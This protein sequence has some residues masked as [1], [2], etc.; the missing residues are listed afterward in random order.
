MSGQ[1]YYLLT[2]LP[3]LGELG[4][5][6]P[7][8]P[9]A[10]LEMLATS[11]GAQ[12]LASAIFLSDDLLLRQAVMS[13]EIPAD[14]ADPAVLSTEQV[15]DEAP[16]PDFLAGLTGPDGE[17]AQEDEAAGTARLG[18]DRVWA[19][20]F[21]HAARLARGSEMLSEWV[22]HEVGLRNALAA[23]RAKALGL[24]AARYIV[25]WQLGGSEDEYAAALSEWSAAPN[26]LAGLQALDAARWNWIAQ[27]S[28]HFTFSD[29]E[30]AA[31]AARLVILHRWKRIAA[32]RPAQAQAP[33][34]G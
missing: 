9:R 2:A 33:G 8:T 27:H 11:P 10:M 14:Q 20:Y 6:P 4:S 19:L 30:L 7:L 26:P 12:Q 21:E 22:R 24:D 34:Q 3:G 18:V 29:D 28:R 31:Y 15:R 13:G 5:D 32:A 25:A 17:T 1:N 23:A 16:L